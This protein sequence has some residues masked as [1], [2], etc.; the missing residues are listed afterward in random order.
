MFP[1]EGMKEMVSREIAEC[2]ET[3]VN[4]VRN[5]TESLSEKGWLLPLA[6]ELSADILHLL[7]PPGR[8]PI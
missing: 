6:G 2:M 4:I 8:A 5:Y 3:V 1:E 7:A